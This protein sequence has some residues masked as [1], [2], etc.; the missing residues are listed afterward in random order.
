MSDVM[1]CENCRMRLGIDVDCDIAGH[2]HRPMRGDQT[3]SDGWSKVGD[4]IVTR[5]RACTPYGL[6]DPTVLIHAR[7]EI[8]RLRAKLEEARRG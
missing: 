5:L 8:E 2:V 4:D 1:W 7:L 6:D 3:G